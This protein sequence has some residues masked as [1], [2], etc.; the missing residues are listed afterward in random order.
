MM[1]KYLIFFCRQKLYLFKIILKISSKKE[2]I[3]KDVRVF[4]CFLYPLFGHRFYS[5]FAALMRK[6]DSY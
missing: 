1:F 3:N 2:C 6:V 5:E 4:F